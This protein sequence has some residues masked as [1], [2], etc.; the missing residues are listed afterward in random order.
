MNELVKIEG[1]QVVDSRVVAEGL[2]R[3]AFETETLK[4]K[5]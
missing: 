4:I 3:M 2:E 1:N 5:V